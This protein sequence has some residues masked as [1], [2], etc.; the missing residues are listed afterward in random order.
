MEIRIFPAS[1]NPMQS[2]GI[3][4]NF[5]S[6]FH[7]DSAYRSDIVLRHSACF[8]RSI[9]ASSASDAADTRTHTFCSSPLPHD[10]SRN[11]LSQIQCTTLV[12]Q[13]QQSVSCTR[14]PFSRIPYSPCFHSQDKNRCQDS[15]QIQMLPSNNQIQASHILQSGSMYEP[16]PAHFVLPFLPVL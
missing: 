6:V 15:Q 7:H 16:F 5:H 9:P 11:H 3:P 14:N 1:E 12:F 10:E 13:F 2:T 4:D 8:A